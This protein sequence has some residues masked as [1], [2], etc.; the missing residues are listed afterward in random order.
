MW[1][2]VASVVACV[3]FYLVERNIDPEKGRALLKILNYHVFSGAPVS[4]MN[5]AKYSCLEFYENFIFNGFITIAIISFFNT[6]FSLSCRKVFQLPFLHSTFQDIKTDAKRQKKTWARFGIPG[7]FFFVFIPM[8][9]TGPVVGSLLAR[10]IGLKYWGML[11]TVIAASLTSIAAWGY[12]AERVEEYFGRGVLN[13]IVWTLI[14]V[15]VAVA[16]VAKLRGWQKERRLAK[17]AREKEFSGEEQNILE[18][19]S[20]TESPNSN[21]SYDEKN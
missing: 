17:E 14:G 1:L 13:V 5:G 10:F 15:T 3:L 6:L 7:V 12:A 9:L 19:T 20:D 18:E 4:A 21:E 16:A 8:P 2:G 11:G